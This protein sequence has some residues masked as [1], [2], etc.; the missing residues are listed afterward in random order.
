[1]GYPV[2]LDEMQ[3]EIII[4]EL[5]NRLYYRS[6]NKCSYCK[7]TLGKSPTCKMIELHNDIKPMSNEL[8]AKYDRLCKMFRESI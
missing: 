2:S 5:L 6:L 1:M 4:K 7:G 8:F 3:E